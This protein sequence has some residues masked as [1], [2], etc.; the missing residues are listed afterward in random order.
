MVFNKRRGQLMAV[1]ETAQ[2]GG[3]PAARESSAGSGGVATL[4]G[5]CRS[6]A[7]AMWLAIGALLNS[8][9]N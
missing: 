9:Q 3:K 5:R 1:A 6:V 4:P 8:T 7:V 2:A